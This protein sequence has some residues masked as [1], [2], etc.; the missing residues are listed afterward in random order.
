VGILGSSREVVRYR[1]HIQDGH[2]MQVVGVGTWM[3]PAWL[4]SLGEP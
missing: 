1:R 3:L 2:R 4:R